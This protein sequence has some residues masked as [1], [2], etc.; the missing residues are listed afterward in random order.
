MENFSPKLRLFGSWH[1]GHIVL[2]LRQ[3]G[4]RNGNENHVVIQNEEFIPIA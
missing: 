2:E 3:D 4:V 1:S